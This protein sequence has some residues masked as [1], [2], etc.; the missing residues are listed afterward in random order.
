M[1]R[2]ESSAEVFHVLSFILFPLMVGGEAK[3]EAFDTAPPPYSTKGSNKHEETGLLISLK[4]KLAILKNILKR[5]KLVFTKIK[6][7]LQMISCFMQK[8]I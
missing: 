4:L 3:G 5:A 2:E 1:T 8:Y 7:D 6:N